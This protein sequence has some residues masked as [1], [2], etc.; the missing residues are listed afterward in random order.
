MEELFGTAP[1]LSKSGEV[2]PSE[3]FKDAKVICIYFSMHNCPPCREFTPIFA[4]LYNETNESEKQIE[5]IFV[6]GDKTQEEYELYYGEMPW[7]A[8]PKGDSRLP[9]LAK[10]F[11]VKGVPRLIVLKPDGTVINNSAVQKVTQEGPAA[12][13]EFL[14]A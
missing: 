6:S 8:L 2:S 7:L 9:S 10:K 14:S 3:G 11:E 12:I 5:V 1:I 4:E 13:Q